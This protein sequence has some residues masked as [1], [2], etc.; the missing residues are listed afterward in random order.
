MARASA[1]ALA[2]GFWLAIAFA[3]LA[4][5][6]ACLALNKASSWGRSWVCGGDHNEADI[7]DTRVMVLL[8]TNCVCTM[9]EKM[10]LFDTTTV[11]TIVYTGVYNPPGFLHKI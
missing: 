4:A 5:A 2:R 6:M 8:S 11:P 9:A 10:G 7:V 1:L 3:L